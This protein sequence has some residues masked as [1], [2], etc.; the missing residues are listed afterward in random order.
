MNQF[1]SACCCCC[2]YYLLLSVLFFA[3]MDEWAIHYKSL[4]HSPSLTILNC[5][6]GDSK[7]AGKRRC[8]L[9]FTNWHEKTSFV[10]SFFS[11]WN[12]AEIFVTSHSF[13]F[14]HLDKFKS[15]ILNLNQTFWLFEFIYIRNLNLNLIFFCVCMFSYISCGG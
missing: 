6:L 13:E 9:L 2:S 4:Y 11:L 10:S 14:A 7:G 5:Q 15:Q 3:E 8:L 12:L 1:S